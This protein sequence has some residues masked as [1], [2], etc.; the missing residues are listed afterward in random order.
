MEKQ[1]AKPLTENDERHGTVEEGIVILVHDAPE[2]FQFAL[3]FVQLGCQVCRQLANVR[4]LIGGTHCLL[5]LPT[6][7]PILANRKFYFLKTQKNEGI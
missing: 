2:Q 7:F 1:K 6:L 4:L 3:E 5:C